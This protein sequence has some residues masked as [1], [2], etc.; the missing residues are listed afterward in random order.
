MTTKQK[1]KCPF[2]SEMVAP[3][4]VEENTIRRDRCKCPNPKCGEEIYLCRSP[5][6]HDFAKGTSVYDH[7]F[8]PSCTETVSNTASEVGKAALKVAVTVGSA[9]AV[10]ALVTKK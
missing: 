1:G 7:E 6:C 10:A 9:V 3:E 4:I 2:C 8:C 5:G